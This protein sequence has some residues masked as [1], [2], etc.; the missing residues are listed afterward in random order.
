MMLIVQ[1]FTVGMIGFGLGLLATAGF[2]MGALQ[3]EQPP[4]YMSWHIPAFALAVILLICAFA[5]LL[6][7]WRVS[8]FEPAMVFRA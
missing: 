6:G 3:N 2:A 1:A 7:I 5:A 4:F 8:R